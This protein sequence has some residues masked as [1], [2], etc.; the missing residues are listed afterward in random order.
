MTIRAITLSGL[1]G[2]LVLLADPTS[3]PAANSSDTILQSCAAHDLAAFSL[4]EMQ[5]EA[6]AMPAQNLVDAFYEMLKARHA[7]GEGRFADALTI[8]DK[9]GLELTGSI[10]NAAL[11]K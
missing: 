11:H 1:A 3:T 4:I 6:E 2:L 10:N 7:C 9:I 5:G 8:Y